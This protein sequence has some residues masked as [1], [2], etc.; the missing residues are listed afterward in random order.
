MSQASLLLLLPFAHS[1]SLSLSLPVLSVWGGRLGNSF[2]LLYFRFLWDLNMHTEVL[3]QSMLVPLIL[4]LLSAVED[5]L[6]QSAR[7]VYALLCFF[8]FI[9]CSCLYLAVSL[10]S[11]EEEGGAELCWQRQC[12]TLGLGV[13]NHIHIYS[14]FSFLMCFLHR[15]FTTLPCLLC[16]MPS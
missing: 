15:S 5:T 7:W 10:E 16:C 12:D 4:I 9:F 2:K 14:L 11:E 3:V 13:P 6:L 1:L 8:L